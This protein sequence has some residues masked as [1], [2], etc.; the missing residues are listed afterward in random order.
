MHVNSLPNKP[1][2]LCM[3]AAYTQDIAVLDAELAVG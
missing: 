1:C 2:S 3:S